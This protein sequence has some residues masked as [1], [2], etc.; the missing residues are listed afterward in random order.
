MT[1]D[2]FDQKMFFTYDAENIV[3]LRPSFS[4][5]PEYATTCNFFF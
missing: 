2:P 1:M 4:E 3:E 5:F